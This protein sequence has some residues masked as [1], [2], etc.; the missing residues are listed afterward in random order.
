MDVG[1]TQHARDVIAERRLS[2]NWMRRTLER[3]Q[4]VQDATDGTR[5]FLAE[6]PER[7]GR[8][9]RV[10]ANASVEPPLVITAFPDRRMQGRLQ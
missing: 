8:V 6:V 3:P 10:V 1:F 7:D 2:L 4:V 5:H 9:L